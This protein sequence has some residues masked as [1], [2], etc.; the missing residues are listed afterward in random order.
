[1][2]TILFNRKRGFTIYFYFIRVKT[3]LLNTPSRIIRGFT[4]SPSR[5]SLPD[6]IVRIKRVRHKKRNILTDNLAFKKLS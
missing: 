3:L 2:N 5:T 1:M 6:F 4:I